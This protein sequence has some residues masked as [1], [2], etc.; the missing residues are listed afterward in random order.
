VD[1]APLLELSRLVRMHWQAEM[2]AEN[3]RQASYRAHEQLERERGAEGELERLHA[4]L[5]T[6]RVRLGLRAGRMLD[7]LRGLGG[8]P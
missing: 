8:S 1:G 7:S 5:G 4:L 6:R 2:R 3:L